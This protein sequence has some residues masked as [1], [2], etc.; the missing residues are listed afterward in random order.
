MQRAII[1]G[2]LFL[3]PGHEGPVPAIIGDRDEWCLP[4]QVQGHIQA[5]RLCGGDATIR[6]VEGAQHSFDSE[7]AIEK[8]EVRVRLAGRTDHVFRR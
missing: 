6:I 8:V 3:P 7:T 1:G 5:M 2:K 4:Q